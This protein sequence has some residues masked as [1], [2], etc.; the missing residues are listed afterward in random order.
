V[1]GSSIF[2]FSGHHLG[3]VS[4]P[5]AQSKVSHNPKILPEESAQV[6]V[7]SPCLRVSVVGFGVCVVDTKTL[8]GEH[9]MSEASEEVYSFAPSK[10]QRRFA[11]SC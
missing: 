10:I 3:V 7:L 9:A 8:L 6:F 11:A 5:S 4:K 1:V 2:R